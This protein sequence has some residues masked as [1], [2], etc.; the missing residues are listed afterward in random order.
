MRFMKSSLYYSTIL[1]FLCCSCNQEQKEHDRAGPYP[2]QT[3]IQFFSNPLRAD[4]FRIELQG[5]QVK[6]M[7]LHFTI[8]AAGGV[9]VY[10]AH[11][12]A[13]DL[14][15]NYKESLDLAKE[16]KK[17]AFMEQELKLFFDE[18]N[19]LEPAVTTEEQPDK[20]TP[21]PTFFEELKKNGLNG[22][23]YRLGK[24]TK[25]YIAWS[26]R[27]KKVKPYYECCQ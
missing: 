2:S 21:D 22:F 24:E 1:L 14:I 17:S 7:A 26:A 8:T 11:L 10:T 16:K 27:E 19:F 13:T 3:K 5:K 25:I 23:K 6:D 18:E 12:R 20:N 15:A 9:P 4:T